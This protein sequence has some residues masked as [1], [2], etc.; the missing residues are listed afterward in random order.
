M[1]PNNSQIWAMLTGYESLVRG[2]L[3]ACHGEN[4]FWV[5]VKGYYYMTLCALAKTKPVAC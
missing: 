2:F 3:K 4:I 5:F 1:S